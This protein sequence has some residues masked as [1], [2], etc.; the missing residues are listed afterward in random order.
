M[1]VVEVGL[2]FSLIFVDAKQ[3]RTS[4]LDV[5]LNRSAWS[6]SRNTARN[7]AI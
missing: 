1:G 4:I 5:E 7:R 6:I 2:R 3:S